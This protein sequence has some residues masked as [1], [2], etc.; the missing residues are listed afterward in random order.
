MLIMKADLL[1]KLTSLPIRRADWDAFQLDPRYQPMEAWGNQGTLKTFHQDWII[2]G[3]V[4]DDAADAAQLRKWV[5]F[6]KKLRNKYPNEFT[7]PRYARFHIRPT[8]AQR[9]TI[10]VY[11]TPAAEPLCGVNVAML[12][13]VIRENSE[14]FPSW[15]QHEVI[16]YEDAEK[17]G[18]K[19]VGIHFFSL[20][21]TWMSVEHYQDLWR[22]W[23]VSRLPHPFPT[24]DDEGIK[25]AEA[26]HCQ[27]RSKLKNSQWQMDGFATTITPAKLK[28]GGEGRKKSASQIIKVKAT[29]VLIFS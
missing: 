22:N 20:Y 10:K 25:K 28:K 4:Y 6:A 29:K 9:S 16:G 12:E 1:A 7:H 17:K 19:I 24:N 3:T 13:L 23:N 5:A 2:N 27:L 15:T 11:F 26:I 8:E 18:L 21:F 14:K